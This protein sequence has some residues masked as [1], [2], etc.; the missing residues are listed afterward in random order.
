MKGTNLAGRQLAS[1]IA[2]ASVSVSVARSA[3]GHV[4]LDLP[5]LQ[6]QRTMA[7]RRTRQSLWSRCAY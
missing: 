1:G 2:T 6:M 4:A 3:R 7:H 5:E